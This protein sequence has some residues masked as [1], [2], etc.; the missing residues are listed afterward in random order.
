[1][2]PIY[3]INLTSKADRWERISSRLDNFQM[4]YTRFNAVD[5]W[6]LSQKDIEA[7]FK[8]KPWYMSWVR[9]L[10]RP[11]IGC[12]ISHLSIWNE[13]AKAEQRGAFILEDDVAPDA[14]LIRVME[15]ISEQ[16]FSYPVLIKL[17]NATHPYTK[18]VD[19]GPITNDHRLVIPRDVPFGAGCYYINMSAA[20]ELATAR[21]T[22]HR[23]VDE[24]M[25]FRWE[26]NVRVCMV[27]PPPLIRHDIHDSSIEP[28]KMYS[29]GGK[30]KRII[31]RKIHY[32]LSNRIYLFLLNF[33]SP[34]ESKA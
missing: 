4:A 29:F 31:R 22:F 8:P 27:V 11:E 17:L 18:W 33:S 21:H 28:Y 5:G 7:H 26:T 13:V 12:Y 19:Y 24:D 25:R 9:R 20:K 2:L 6:A 23:A 16:N 10:V 15:E 32:S 30:L 3:V 34:D 14:N 1:M